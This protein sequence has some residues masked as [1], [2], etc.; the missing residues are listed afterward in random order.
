MKKYLVVAGIFCASFLVF[1]FAAGILL[2][3]FYTPDISVAW[4]QTGTL[5]SETT[6]VRGNVISPLIIA[7]TSVL[8]TFGVMQLLRKRID[9]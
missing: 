6:L 1:Q 3:L 4:Q 9:R 7:V 2:T 8:V 5:S